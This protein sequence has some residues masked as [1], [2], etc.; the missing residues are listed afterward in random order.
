M[1]WASTGEIKAQKIWICKP[2]VFVH[3]VSAIAFFGL[4]ATNSNKLHTKLI[5]IMRFVPCDD[6]FVKLIMP[7]NKP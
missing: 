2:A 4:G 7:Y 3:Q 6:L 1:L 5:F